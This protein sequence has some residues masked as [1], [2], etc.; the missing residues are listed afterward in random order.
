MKTIAFIAALGVLLLLYATQSSHAGGSPEAAK[1]QSSYAQLKSDA[2]RMYAEGSYAKAYEIYA[3]IDKKT[4]SE[5]EARWVNFRIADTS[6]RAQSAT[7]T[8]D[9]TKYE[10]AQKQLEELIRTNDKEE[11]RD[12]VWVEA[13][14]SLGDF[15]WVRRNMMN[16]GAAWQHYHAAL[17]WWAGQRDIEPARARY[18]KIVFKAAE[19]P[20]PNEYYYYTYYGN[21]IPLD[22]LENAL[23]ISTTN[24]EKT[25]LHYLIAMTMR[26]AGGDWEARQRVPEEFEFALSLGKQT[27]WYDD[28]LYYYAEWMASTGTIRQLDEGQWTQEPDYIKALELFRRL[29]REF[30]KGETRY[31]D[32]AQA[33]IK[34]ITEPSI[35]VMVENIFLPESELRFVLN[36]RNV[37][38]ADFALY[39]VQLTQDVRFIKNPDDEEGEA[40]NETWLQKLPLAGR[41]PVKTWSKN[42]DSEVDHKPISE[43]V[44]IEGKLPV[45]AYLLE[46]KAGTLNARELIL[47]TD[48]SVVL[49][50]SG[51]QALVYFCNALT[52]APVANASAVLWEGYYV[53]DKWRWRRLSQTTNG[54][55]LAASMRSPIAPRIVRRKRAVE[56]HRAPF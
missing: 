41:V 13:Y 47:I 39:K 44:R 25:H 31:Y 54:D 36:A 23:K 48:V 7:E 16:W 8:A 14:E 30:A 33:Q 53:K 34:N 38:R 43:Q 42:L 22:I 2:E 28:A 27:E 17:D 21:Y 19:P 56:I 20:R 12:L 50:A 52:G 10:L 24:N 55:G 15:F 49:K 51:K 18:L 11:E 5:A 4:I 1:T 46:A 3:N 26:Y 37:K 6:W 9:N 45:G 29:I 40:D 32:Q 35:G